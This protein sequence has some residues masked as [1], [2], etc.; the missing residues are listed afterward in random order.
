[1]WVEQRTVALSAGVLATLAACGQAFSTDGSGDGGGDSSSDSPGVTE[2]GSSGGEAGAGDAAGDA[3]NDHAGGDGSAHDAVTI[4]GPPPHD[5]PSSE[6]PAEVGT[7][8]V[9]VGGTKLVFV[10]SISLTGDLGGLDGADLKCQ[11]LAKASSR[12]GTF[13]AW[14][15]STTTSAA[16][17]LTHSTGPYVLVN[18]TQVAADWAGLTSGT[19]LNP[20]SMS[21]TG[22]FPPQSNILCSSTN[23]PAAWTA[24][25]P[26]GTLATTV[27]ATCA[28]WT[29]SGPSN[30]AV[31]G[32]V[33]S[34]SATWTDG[35]SSQ[36]P[37]G[38]STMCAGAAALYCIE[39]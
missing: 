4:D 8:D 25:A 30:G 7:G 26:D 35:C 11:T 6:G 33:A 23:V 14:L 2:G 18:G 21:E 34:T 31:L 22:G 12:S 10:S 13:K 15:S 39:Q 1:M 17:R 20:I 24:T 28:D 32:I 27:G 36:V 3:A 16:S 37:G 9:V 38:T 19:L 29:T 5:A